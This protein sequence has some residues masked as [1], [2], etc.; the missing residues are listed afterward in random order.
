M[1]ASAPTRPLDLRITTTAWPFVLVAWTSSRLVFLVTGV[2]AHAYLAPVTPG[3]Y[4]REPAGALNYWAHWDGGWFASIAQY[5]YGGSG[6]GEVTWPAST[7]F[8]PL[9][10]MTIRAGTAVAGGPAL[11]GVLISLTASLAALYFLYEL[12]RDLFDTDV[13]RAATLALAFFPTAFFLNAVYSEGVFLAAAIGAVW[14]ARVRRDFVAAG[15]LGCLAAATRNVGVVLLLP[16]AHEW[17]RQRR[18]TRVEWRTAVPLALV[19][20]GL[21]AY[22]FWLWRWSSHPLLFSTVVQRV[23]G[24]HLASPIDTLDRAWDAASFGAHW[25]AHP[26]AVLSTSDTNPFWNALDTYNFAFLV[27]LALVVVG[28]AIRLPVGLALYAIAVAAFPV[29]TPASVQPL[30]SLPRYFLSVFP[31]FIFLGTVLGRNRLALAAWLAVSTA[32][33]ILFTVFFTT[34]RWVA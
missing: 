22:M 15:A 24:R 5:G 32:L 8:F 12:S 17:I 31:A 3:G 33:G 28:T 27:L 1:T 7:N 14:A 21:L 19:P 2:L 11:W 25:A 26:I 9:Y 29:L 10:P 13:A 20:A 30:A 23:W 34:W 16:L 6:H 4:P 18:A